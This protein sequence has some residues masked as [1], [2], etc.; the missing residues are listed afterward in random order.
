[1]DDKKKYR[2]ILL[3]VLGVVGLVLV[4]VLRPE[5]GKWWRHSGVVWATEYHIQ[6]FADRDYSDSILEV[7]RRVEMSVSAFAPESTVSKINNN[8]SDS[9]DDVMAYMIESSRE[10]SRITAGAFD[11]TVRPLV[12]AWGFGDDDMALPDTAQ[13]DSLRRLVGIDKV[14]VV[15]GRIQKQNAGTQLDFSA[16]AKGFGCDEI[17]RMLQRNGVKDCLVEVGGEIAMSGHNSEGKLWRISIDT[18]EYSADSACRSSIMAFSMTDCGVATSGNYRNYHTAADGT[19]YGHI[20]DPVTGFPRQTDVLSATVCAPNCTTADALATAFMVLGL[21]RSQAV[22]DAYPDVKAV[23][24]TADKSGGFK[25][26]FSKNW[27]ANK[28]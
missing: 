26:V 2:A 15:D 6:Y 22:V 25:T 7:F 20:I 5:R 12:N 1:M 3:A 28:K 24:I 21:E 18:P 10:L 19:H 4:F 17:V 27:P 16:I 9:V 14:K 11:P 8:R 23:F 13:V